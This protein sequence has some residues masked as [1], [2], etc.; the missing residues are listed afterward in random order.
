MLRISDAK[1]HLGESFDQREYLA[2]TKLAN[3][4]KEEDARAPKNHN[5]DDDTAQKVSFFLS[6]FLFIESHFYKHRRYFRLNA[7]VKC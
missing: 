4:C 3:R 7:K 1:T 2:G 6:F 5:W